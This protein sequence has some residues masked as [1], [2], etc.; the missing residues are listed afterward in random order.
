MTD[1]V[2]KPLAVF[3]DSETI[4]VGRIR[5]ALADLWQHW[6]VDFHDPSI[7]EAGSTEQVYMRASTV[8][9]ILAA[10]TEADARW[11]EAILSHLNEYSPSRTLILVRNGRSVEQNSYRVHIKVE[12]RQHTR[13]IVPVRLETI[14]ILAPPGNDQS[15]ASLASPL[16]IPDLPDVLFVPYGPIA[17]NLLVSSLFELVDILVVDTVWV[18]NTGAAFA[19][20]A[21]SAAHQDLS[22][23]NDIAWS[24]LLV[25]RQLV[26]QFF[27]QPAALESIETIE[28][29]E[30]TYAPISD[31]GRGGRSAALLTAGWLATRLGWR[32][33]G[34]MV[35]FR[36]GWRSTLRAGEKGKTREIVL[37][38]IEGEDDYGCGCLQ[39]IRILAGGNARGDFEVARTSEDEITTTSSHG[40]GAAVTR[41]VH[42]RCP[43]DRYLVSQELRRLHE[44]PAYTA[45][46]DFA[47]LL[48]PAGMD[49]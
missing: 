21:S 9:V 34:E 44:D 10:D 29:V 6:T 3:W 25:W 40:D 30:I 16:L 26:A 39:K 24:R 13:G 37:M 2:A 20:L 45:A 22:D 14:T 12:E 48:W 4:E 36:D 46:L 1:T 18:Q 5:S 19:V 33:P 28:E 31:Q 35:K 17:D 47:A 49:S 41:I 38:L 27:D 8:N 42:S 7:I 15:L 11:A 32:A 23:I 43:D